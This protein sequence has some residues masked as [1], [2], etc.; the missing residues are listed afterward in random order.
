MKKISILLSLILFSLIS[1][2]QIE[3]PPLL[4]G[5]QESR[6][7]A[8]VS[9]KFPVRCGSPIGTP[10]PST[11]SIKGAGI[12]MDTCNQVIYVYD[13]SINEWDTISG[14]SPVIPFVAYGAQGIVS[15]GDTLY[16]GQSIG[17]SGNPAHITENREI[18]M[19]TLTSIKIFQVDEDRGIMLYPQGS[20]DAGGSSYTGGQFNA[21]TDPDKFN[22][23]PSFN[24]RKGFIGDV[25]SGSNQLTAYG[26][27]WTPN[28]KHVYITDIR[29]EITHA[30]IEVNGNSIANFHNTGVITLGSPT[31]SRKVRIGSFASTGIGQK[32]RVDGSSRFT[33]SVY[34]NNAPLTTSLTN[35]YVMLLGVD[36]VVRKIHPDSLG[37]S[38]TSGMTNPMTMEGSIIVGGTSGS[39]LELQP[40]SE[41]DIL[42][43]DSD[44]L[45]AWVGAASH[46]SNYSWSKIGNAGTTAETNFIGTTDA[47]SL[48]FKVNN[49][50]SFYIDATTG[51]IIP[52]TNNAISLG[53][54]SSPSGYFAGVYANNY[55]GSSTTRAYSSNQ[56]IFSWNTS[57][58]VFNDGSSARNLRMESDGDANN[59][60][61]DGTNNRVGIGTATPS[62]KLEVVGNIKASGGKVGVS[63]VNN[64]TSVAT[65][66]TSENDLQTYS[67]EAG[68]L[69]AT[70][71]Y[72]EVK[73]VFFC[74]TVG[75]TFRLKF[76]STNVVDL[77][78]ANIGSHS[79]SGTITRTGTTSQVAFFTVI[80]PDNAVFIT[81]PTETLSGAITIKGTAQGVG[82]GD[83]TQYQLNVKYY[84]TN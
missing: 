63:L 47:Q 53:R 25:P 69:S 83:I 71:D 1:F 66:N 38:G 60:Y 2:S 40:G 31:A 68:K 5:K 43:I 70:G 54:H 10:F 58:F 15:S 46:L 57:G 52:A 4:Y 3:Q 41:D 18:P 56:E 20:I 65:I 26:V 34:I 79:I 74:T 72:V 22:S 80:G 13:P 78:G 76:G 24:I 21:W 62:E 14:S 33:D 35:Q 50:S 48:Y 9:F 16:L 44:N 6:M 67:L 55:Y 39:P 37:G 11:D 36:S 73:A 7:T 27:H 30:A 12:V 32:F 49:T 45:P 19:D 77:V 59:F 81:N 23:Y 42:Y 82:A 28:D 17:A 61:S 75:Q 8:L 29:N 84:P 64:V 51:D